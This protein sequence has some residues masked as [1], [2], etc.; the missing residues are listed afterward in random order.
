[1]L[2]CTCDKS[3][4]TKIVLNMLKNPPRTVLICEDFCISYLILIVNGLIDLDVF[5]VSDLPYQN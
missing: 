5:W 2:Y 1:M 4:F 3:M